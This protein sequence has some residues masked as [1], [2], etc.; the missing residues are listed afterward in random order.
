MIARILGASGVNMGCNT[1]L[2]YDSK[3][4]Q[5]ECVDTQE[6]NMHILGCSQKTFSLDVYLPKH[7]VDLEDG[8]I[9]KIKSIIKHFN[10][11]NCSNWGFKD[12]RTCLIWDSWTKYAR[13]SRIVAIW[14]DPREVMNHYIPIKPFYRQSPFRLSRA[15]KVLRAWFY[16]NSCVLKAIGMHTDSILFEYSSFVN[17]DKPIRNLEKFLNFKVN[18]RRINK[19]YRSKSRDTFL[20][21]L[22]SLI[23]RFKGLNIKRIQNQLLLNSSR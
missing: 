6:V 10:E 18:D 16:H 1:D 5:Y 7:L 23:C 13:N 2:K 9:E 11:K 17:Q 21:K 22:A 19:M 8:D 20:F 14:R 3:G 12:P 15:F 4:G